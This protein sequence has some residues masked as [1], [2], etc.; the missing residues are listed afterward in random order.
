MPTKSAVQ[1]GVLIHSQV[2]LL[3]LKS[4]ASR[5]AMQQQA[6]LSHQRPSLPAR[7]S[8]QPFSGSDKSYEQ[9]S[10]TKQATRYKQSCTSIPLPDSSALS[11]RFSNSLSLLGF[12]HSTASC[13]CLP[14]RR[15]AAASDTAAQTELL[16]PA[17]LL[18]SLL[19]M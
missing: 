14:P 4:V 8:R 1:H 3:L 19:L 7:V 9:Q 2:L 6:I 16:A 12:L 18:R 15:D 13:C 11:V 17:Y 10:K 5:H